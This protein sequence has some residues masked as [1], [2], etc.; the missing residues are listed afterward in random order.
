VDVT[1]S[2]VLATWAAGLGGGLVFVAHRRMVGR[3]YVWLA[4]GVTALFGV[5][6]AAAG[7]LWAGY[8]GSLCV[9]ATTLVA[10]RPVPVMALSGAGSGLFLVAALGSQVHPIAVITGALVLGAVTTEMMLGHW[11]LVDPRLPRPALRVL[12]IAGAAGAGIDAVTVAVL[13]AVP[14]PGEDSVMGFGFL[15]LAVTTMV[16]MALVHS[17]LGER[18]YSGVMAATGLSYLAVLTS[19]G[20]V[21]VGRVLV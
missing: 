8:A 5:T 4:G 9:L 17:S 1:P 19:I 14:W 6:A 13:G 12:A 15:V 2:G 3:G 16:L 7:G 11:Y 21:V 18:G 10:S 20:A